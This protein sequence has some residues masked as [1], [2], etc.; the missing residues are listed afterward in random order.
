MWLTNNIMINSLLELTAVIIMLILRGDRDMQIN[1][2]LIKDN[3]LI[4][5]ARATYYVIGG[6][7]NFDKKE[8]FL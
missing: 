4:S 1:I 5:I 6:F 2:L 3:K 8:S 7:K